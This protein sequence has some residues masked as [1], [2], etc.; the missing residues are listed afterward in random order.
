MISNIFNAT[1]YEPLYNG[2]IFLVGHLPSH[3]VGIAVVILTIIVRFILYPLSKRAVE[4]QMAM[5]KVAPEIEELKVK[6]KND[7]E[8]Q[9]KAIFKL[10]RD[11]NIHPFAGLAIVLLQFPILIGLYWVFAMGGL[12]K[13]D[14]SILYSFVTTPPTVNMEFLGILDVR[15]H[16][17]VL[18][19]L[20]AITQFIYTRLSMGAPGAKDPSPVESSLAGDLARSFDLQARYVL[21][22]MI[23]VISYT[24]AAAA[25][26]YWTTSNLFMIAQEYLSGKRFA[27][28]PGG[29]VAE[30]KAKS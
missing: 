7:R 11:R 15:S 10:Y 25:P 20:A 5:K 2:L 18:A 4:A 28:A 30:I 9:S 13:V 27:D 24:V 19:V 16:S 14:P 8:A 12:P 29:E 1:V 26:L 22:I 17:I 3:D 23:G 6:Y 21:P